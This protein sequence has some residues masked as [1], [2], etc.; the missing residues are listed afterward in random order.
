M[1]NNIKKIS[2]NINIAPMNTNMTTIEFTESYTESIVKKLRN[3]T[4]TSYENMRNKKKI[5]TNKGEDTSIKIEVMN[6]RKLCREAIKN[7]YK[8]TLKYKFGK[9]RDSGRLYTIGPSMQNIP[10]FIRGAICGDITL[11]VDA[12]NC[13]PALLLYMCKRDNI[14]HYNLNTYVNS[15]EET[16]KNIMETE[17]IT[18][19]EAKQLFLKCLNKEGKTTKIG[20][21][22]IKNTFFRNFDDE[23]RNIINIYIQKN[24]EIY[25]LIQ[26]EHVDN[27]GGKLM[28]RLLNQEEGIMLNEAIDTLKT[29]YIIR[30]L[31]FD[32]L[33]IDCRTKEGE[34][35]DK[36][37]VVSLLNECTKLKEIKWSIKLHDRSMIDEIM[38][39][40]TDIDD[41]IVIYGDTEMDIVESLFKIKFTGR[42]WRRNGEYYLRENRVW[43]TN[44][45]HIVEIIRKAVRKT[46]GLVEHKDSKGN[47]S[48]ENITQSLTKSKSVIYAL[49]EIV[50][51]NPTFIEDVEERC[52]RKLSFENG[53]I[54]FERGRFIEYDFNNLHYDTINIIHRDF[55]YISPHDTR[56]I[57]LINKILKP[58]FCVDSED[59]DEFNLMEYFLH[60]QARAM[61]GER[62]DKIYT[63][64]CGVRDSCKS[65]Y[66]DLLFGTFGNYVQMFNISTFELKRND[67]DE[68][69]QLGS[70]LKHRHARILSSQEVSEKWLNGV[71]L[72]KVSSGGDPITAR[73]LYKEEETFVPEFKIM[74]AGNQN[75]RVRPVDALEKCLQIDLKCNFVD[76]IPQP[77]DRDV[78]IKYYIKDDKLKSKYL[79]KDDTRNA[80]ASLIM[81][82][83]IRTD[84]FYPEK[85]RPIDDVNINPKQLIK[86]RF[87]ITN[88]ETDRISNEI[89]KNQIYNELK[90][91]FDS[92]QQLKK[93]LKR[94]G[95]TDYNNRGRGL[96]GL[97][98][99]KYEDADSDEECDGI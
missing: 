1:L 74:F 82:Y 29:K 79:I 21:Y 28:A 2:S 22:N 63:S 10:S 5:S 65:I 30:T 14:P 6:I 16:L 47:I 96:Q 87:E 78:G 58:M 95:A 8:R 90:D 62:E 9:N 68:S 85:I 42:F 32:G 94:A 91:Y 35:V 49:Q 98:Y 25:E 13:H 88:N 80:M 3:I 59:S 44:K 11:D 50:P 89:L 12:Q 40:G 31:A 60:T 7:N 81:D 17:N 33:M 26:N 38:N 27:H 48:Y 72:K 69:R 84:T 93:L 64:I 34:S 37:E 67:N 66:N 39:L 41:S 4:H 76:K 56:R 45:N 71:L 83:Y 73:C 92:A 77:D 51:E 15:R 99:I 20:K 24:Q 57:E 36:Q 54:D 18:R 55:E 61:A 43:I 75:Q 52:I 97:R 19:P 86:E 46:Q 53:Y 23:M 70:L